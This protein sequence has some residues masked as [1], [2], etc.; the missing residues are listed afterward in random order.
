MNTRRVALAV[1]V[2]AVA[3]GVTL[4]VAP[5]FAGAFSTNRTAVFALGGLAALL[6][7]RALS[8]RRAASREAASLPE[9]ES[10]VTF[11]R[12]G[13]DYIDR[14]R[15]AASS[16]LNRDARELRAELRETAVRVLTTYD[17]YTQDGAESALDAGT[18]TDDPYAAAFFARTTP[19][20]PL[21]LQLRDVFRGTAAFDH[22]ATRAVAEL[23]AIAEEA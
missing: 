21:R 18:W 16:R 4:V 3:L 15:E 11:D 17:G 6:A 23:A 12:P 7:I 22:R 9:V 8:T 5:G 2:A 13:T 14:I 20:R 19:P 10:R 1:G